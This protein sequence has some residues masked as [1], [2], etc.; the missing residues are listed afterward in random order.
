MASSYTSDIDQ[1]REQIDTRSP[2][3][4]LSHGIH[5]NQPAFI[6]G[7]HGGVGGMTSSS[8][9]SASLL[10]QFN[11]FSQSSFNTQLFDHSSGLS[12]ASSQ[13][14]NRLDNGRNNLGTRGRYH[15]RLA[16]SPNFRRH[17]VTVNRDEKRLLKQAEMTLNEMGDSRAVLEIAF[18]GEVGFGLGPTLEFYT[19]ISRLLM[20]SNLNLW[21]GCESTSDGYLIAPA[22]GLYPRPFSRQT[23]SSVIREVF[24]LF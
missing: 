6:T 2:T 12:S 7:L 16:L 13:E 1:N 3:P 14:H 11:A 20:K 19:L 4:L 22:P 24:C 10:A 9:N 8:S 15:L 17:K 5:D 18:E 21:H 23:K